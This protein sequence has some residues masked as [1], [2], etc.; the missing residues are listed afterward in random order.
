MTAARGQAITSDA[1]P[2][3]LQRRRA[4]ASQPVR[5]GAARP[6][7]VPEL[8]APELA[9]V[10]NG[11]RVIAGSGM[12]VS[13]AQARRRSGVPGRPVGQRVEQLPQLVGGGLGAIT[14][15][16]LAGVT[17]PTSATWVRGPGVGAVRTGGWP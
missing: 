17:A 13:G 2:G 7:P 8:A 5:P 3:C 4:Q 9:A 6:G 1:S 14:N 12:V 11:A 16:R 15:R 10:E